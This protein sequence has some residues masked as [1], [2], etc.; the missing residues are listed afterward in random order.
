MKRFDHSGKFRVLA[1]AV[2]VLLAVYVLLN[3]LQKNRPA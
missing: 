2:A 1:C 3:R